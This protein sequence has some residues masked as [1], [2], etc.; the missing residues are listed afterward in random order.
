MN[1]RRRFW[2][3]SARRRKERF[4]RALEKAL[5]DGEKSNR[6]AAAAALWRITRSRAAI[7]SLMNDARNFGGFGASF[8]VM[9]LGE[10]GPADK[11]VLP[12]LIEALNAN[13]IYE[14]AP[15]AQAIGKL[16]PE[17]R[18]AIPRLI[19]IHNDIHNTERASF[20]AAIKAIDPEA[21]AR[22][23]VR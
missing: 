5:G 7:S 14:Q 9:A 17:A 18:A 1:M 8:A 22:A 11:A 4:L 16:G 13:S 2:D 10:I 12:A 15:V 20:A 23:G 21:G 3:E 19:E 6:I